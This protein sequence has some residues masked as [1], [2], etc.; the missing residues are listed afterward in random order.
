ML[1]KATMV[2]EMNARGWTESLWKNFAD[3]ISLATVWN[4]AN[5]LAGKRVELLGDQARI[6]AI[7]VSD[8]AVKNDAFLKYTDILPHTGKDCDEPDASIL[9]TLRDGASK[10]FKHI[11]LRGIWDDVDVKGGKLVTTAGDYDQRLVAYVDQITQNSWGWWGINKAAKRTANIIGYTTNSDG[12]VVFS[13]DKNLFEAGQD[14]ERVPVRISKLNGEDGSVLN[15][16]I[17][18][19]V[20]GLAACKTVDS[21]GVLPYKSPGVMTFNPKEFIQAVN[22]TPQ[23]ICTRRVGSPLLE[24]R[25]RA[26][27]RKKG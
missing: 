1:C 9:L 6:K 22:G 10:R 24:S 4:S 8:E 12:Q 27:R 14:K 21:V 5:S 16:E 7:R 11:F 15:G 23:K 25:G 26:R 13:L 3:G 2:F 19:I 20:T 18:V 17:I